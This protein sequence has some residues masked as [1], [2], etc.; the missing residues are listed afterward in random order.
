MDTKEIIK[1]QFMEEYAKKEFSRITV[2][3]LCAAAPVARTTFYAYF[4][5]TDEVKAAVEEDLIGGLMEIAERE[6]GGSGEARRSGTIRPSGLA[7][8]QGPVLLR[9]FY[10]GG[11]FPVQNFPKSRNPESG[12]AYEQ[13]LNSRRKRSNPPP[14]WRRVFLM[15]FFWSRYFFQGA[16]SSEALKL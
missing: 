10:K 8:R 5:N 15:V 6:S 14:D 3:G 7:P 2:K 4:D 12:T 16:S 9:P 13:M 11:Q 1:A